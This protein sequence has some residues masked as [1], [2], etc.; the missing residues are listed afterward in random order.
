MRSKGPVATVPAA[1]SIG[2]DNPKMIS[3]LRT[4]VGNVRKNILVIVPGFCLVRRSVSVV[5]GSSVL[6]VRG[7]AQ[8]VSI[9]G[10]VQSG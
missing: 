4:Q 1:G 9:N 6:K 7:S 2:S 5:G 3:R 10:P 8:S